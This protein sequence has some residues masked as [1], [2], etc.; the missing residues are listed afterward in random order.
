MPSVEVRN[1]CKSFGDLKVLNNLSFK[2][3]DGEYAVVLGLSGCGKTTLLKT[4]AGLLKPG[5]GEIFIDG[6]DVT[7]KPTEERGIGFFFQNYALF[8]HM[9]VYD[10]IAYGLR[11][12]K[13][14]EPEVKKK[15]EDKL[16]MVGLLEWGK[17]MPKELSGGMQQRV[18]LA[19]AISIESKLLLLDEPLNALDAKIGAILRLELV[20]MA[21][22]LG[23]T[24]IHVTPNQAEAM[25]I[26]DKMIIIN[27]GRIAQIGSDVEVYTTPSNPFVAYFL[28]ES[29]FLK[30]SRT[31]FRTVKYGK[32]LFQLKEDVVDDEVLLA[33]KSEKVLFEKHDKN[34]LEGVVENVN[35][36]GK[37]IRYEVAVTGG[38]VYVQTSKYPNL[39][40][41]DRVSVYFPPED[42]LQFTSKQKLHENISVIQYA[43][44]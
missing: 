11:L 42:I 3:E 27:D 20:K 28:G 6:L 44:Y 41:S 2:V 43:D 33:V 40:A 29:N 17:N 15:V 38:R 12:R 30:A 23:L 26:A 1:L 13:V 24:V 9:T 25:E 21:D 35:F 31:D 8:P 16:S 7:S 36:L 22:E 10:N 19:R 18:A 39:K 32:N 37:T 4:M 5:S 14:P 34:T